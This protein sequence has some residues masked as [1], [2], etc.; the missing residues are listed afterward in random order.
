MGNDVQFAGESGSLTFAQ[1]A[2]NQ[3]FAPGRVAKSFAIL[4]LLA[5]VAGLVRSRA[6]LSRN[7][8]A[9]EPKTL[10]SLRPTAK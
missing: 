9:R 7:P 10:H 1:P 5:A 6:A 4:L 3:V 8:K 2:R